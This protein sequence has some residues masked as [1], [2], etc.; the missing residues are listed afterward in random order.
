MPSRY[1]SASSAQPPGYMI[2]L[3]DL[4]LVQLDQPR[5]LV[6]VLLLNRL[7]EPLGVSC[8]ARR[9]LL[10]H[11]HQRPRHVRLVEVV[12][13]RGDDPVVGQQHLAARRAR[14]SAGPRCPASPSA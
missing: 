10:E 6:E 11:L 8:V 4:L 7:E 13:E 9:A 2:D 12:L 5:V 14:R 3:L 1:G